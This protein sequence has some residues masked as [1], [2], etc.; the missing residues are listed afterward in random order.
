MAKLTLDG[1]DLDHVLGIPGGDDDDQKRK[2]SA[3]IP[4]T[5][6]PG[7]APGQIPPAGTNNPAPTLPKKE[8]I[9]TLEGN[10][11]KP[12]EIP[13]APEI[14]NLPAQTSSQGVAAPLV[15]APAEIPKAPTAKESIAAGLAEHP[16]E[17]GNAKAEGKRQFEEMR[18]Q[19]TATPGTPEYGQQKQEQMDYD[20]AHPWGKDISSHPGVLGEIG[21]VLGRIGNVAGDVV[22]PAAMALIPG[23]DLHNEQVAKGNENWIKQGEENNL[24]AAQTGEAYGR[25]WASLHPTASGKTAEEQTFASLLTQV[26]P[27]T[28][29]Q[30]TPQ[31]AFTRVNQIK[32][33]VKPEDQNKQPIGDGG[34]TQH[35]QQLDTLTQ[36]MKPDEKAKFMQA[37]GSDAKTQGNIATKRLED[38]KAAAA[39]SSGERDRALQRDIAQRNHEDQQNNIQATRG[40]ESVQY[41]DENGHMVS[42][43]YND[44]VAA[45]AEKSARKISPE[46]DKANRTVYD[47]FHRWQDNIGAASE[48]MSAWDNPKDKE[49][50]IRAM[51]DIENSW[52][53]GLF[54]T[55]VDINASALENAFLRSDNYD[56]M[57]PAGQQHMQNMYQLWSDAINLM[58]TETGGVPRGEH[59]LKLESAIMPQPEKTQP[60]NRA[61]LQGFSR[62]IIDD[63]GG[64]VRPNDVEPVIPF[65][66]QG[67]VKNNK[68]VT[69]GYVDAAGKRQNF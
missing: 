40:L 9:N 31:E 32:Q 56:H 21:H 41:R 59:F 15:G 37:Y 27:D 69:V 67:T 68:G 30:F 14:P 12:A 35:G 16:E 63:T 17:N 62:R 1:Y 45:G 60:Q 55:G 8:M 23:T 48:S 4:G 66:A 52:S 64:H 36:G 34:A 2:T 42:G 19:V 54:H 33:D 39:L 6:A 38:A 61:A 11:P 22:D 65:D 28:N 29:K 25:E 50:A 49:L 7:Q 20:R 3:V 18:P 57:T 5:P 51:H 46:D 43:S 26:N 44:A 58:K 13:A 47:Q 10:K 24:K 53:A